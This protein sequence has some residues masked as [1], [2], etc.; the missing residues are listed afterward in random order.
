VLAVVQQLEQRRQVLVTA[1]ELLSRTGINADVFEQLLTRAIQF[2][3]QVLRLYA[4]TPFPDLAEALELLNNCVVNLTAEREIT[5]RR[6]QAVNFCR[7]AARLVAEAL[8][9]P[10]QPPEARPSVVPVPESTPQ[11]QPL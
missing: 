1:A 7:N 11:P 8:V 2:H 9:R 4:R 3:A 5:Q 10:L 6:V